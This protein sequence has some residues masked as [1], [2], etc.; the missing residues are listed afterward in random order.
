[1]KTT[2]KDAPVHSKCA[3]NESEM[4]ELF[5]RDLCSTELESIRGGQAAQFNPAQPPS[6]INALF[7]TAG[8]IFDQTGQ[9]AAA[10]SQILGQIEAIGVLATQ[11]PANAAVIILSQADTSMLNN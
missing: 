5:V 4:E 2:R 10:M 6:G 11:T 1:M 7:N 9:A 8:Q 3:S